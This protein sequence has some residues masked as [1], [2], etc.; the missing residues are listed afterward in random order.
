M[1]SRK[2]T[3]EQVEAVVVDP[4][5]LTEIATDFGVSISM[6]YKIKNGTRRATATNGRRDPRPDPPCLPREFSLSRPPVPARIAEWL[7]RYPCVAE[8][9]LTP[10]VGWHVKLAP[11]HVFH[12]E[13]PTASGFVRRV[14]TEFDRPTLGNVAWEIK[15]GWV[16][17]V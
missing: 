9:V 13:V 11:G 17:P 16:R 2:L 3:D 10:K 7:K 15:G 12:D 1:K 6:I 14:V 5:M 8:L 4:R